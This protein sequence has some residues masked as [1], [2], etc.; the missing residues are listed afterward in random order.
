MDLV[1]KGHCRSLGRR[2][3]PRFPQTG[4]REY[5]ISTNRFARPNPAKIA[6]DLLA[7]FSPDQV[8]V[9]EQLLDANQL[10]L[11]GLTL[12]R[13]FLWGSSESLEE[14]APVQGTPIPPGYHLI[15]FTPTQPN[16]AL[17][18]DGT[19]ASFNPAAPFTRRMW[20]GGSCSW[21]GADPQSKSQSLLRVGDT[22]TEITRILSCEPKVRKNGEEMLVMSLEKE[23][24]NSKGE[25]CLTD[26]RNWV[27]RP[28]LDPSKPVSQ[29]PEPP[30][31][32]A[33]VPD[34]D[35][36]GHHTR[37][38]NRDPTV[39][40]RFSALTFNA[41]RIHYDKRWA[42]E[43]EGHRGLV[44]HG[45]LNFIAMLDLWRDEVAARHQESMV[46]PKNIDYRAVHPVYA[47]DPYQVLTKGQTSSELETEVQVVNDEGTICM[48]GSILD[49]PEGG[50]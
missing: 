45:P 36:R 1:I 17:G 39:L 30:K 5:S 12:N 33:A 8:F 46:Y 35:V 4:H 43:I 40:F 32:S 7:K 16:D 48:T 34:K 24:R 21:P 42:T 28:A 37:C 41:H 18:I 19:D 6:E 25:L 9:R 31:R 29:L 38:F 44:V 14:K 11:F 23:F 47:G 2:S 20:A 22:A 50:R 27:F 10:R 13:P 49:W 15:Y 26:R 3:L